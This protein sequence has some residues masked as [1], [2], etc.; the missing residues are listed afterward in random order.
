VWS[1]PR[2]ATSPEKARLEL[3]R[4]YL[5]VFGPSTPASFATWAGISPKGA[6]GAFDAMATQLVPVRT[7]MGDAW[8]LARDEETLRAPAEPPASARLLP[9][10]DPYYLLQ[11][12]DRQLLVPNAK[13]RAELWTS[14]VWPGAVSIEGEVAGT[15][16]RSQHVVRVDPW[17][18]LTTA[19]RETIEEEAASLP[20]PDL[21]RPIVVRW[22]GAEA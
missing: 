14:R 19:E 2:P 13:R 3:F 1:V 6:D 9:S 11:G 15:W 10:G 16:R 4:R 17:R 18:R 5:H 20:L 22:E 7:P 12:R 8:L 21:R